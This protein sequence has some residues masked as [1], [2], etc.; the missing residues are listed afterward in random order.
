MKIAIVSGGFDPIH[1]GHI[2]LFKK[3]RR[4]IGSV[5]VI[6]NS[7]RFLTNKKGKPFM[8]F[9]ER[10]VILENL[11]CV[12]LVIGSID[13][14]ETV[15]KTLEE[16]SNL[17]TKLPNGDFWEKLYFCNGG[18]RTDGSNTPEHELC[19]KVGIESVYGLGSKIQSSSWLING[20]ERS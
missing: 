15:C 5:F 3:A 12:D 10:K 9:K 1:I 13:T 4:Q 7:D 20:E 6:L 14:D 19:G 18:D 16:L 2:E 17:R 8:P 11:N